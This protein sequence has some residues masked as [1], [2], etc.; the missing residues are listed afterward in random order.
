MGTKSELDLMQFS[1]GFVGFSVQVP[2]RLDRS[3]Q[4]VLSATVSC[5]AWLLTSS[6]QILRY[7]SV[8]PSDRRI[9]LERQMELCSCS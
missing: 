4:P 1:T 9:E 2:G 5:A 6:A 7:V 8:A 3:R